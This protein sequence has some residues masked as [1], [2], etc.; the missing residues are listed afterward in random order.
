[1]KTLLPGRH[2]VVGGTE[3]VRENTG[4]EDFVFDLCAPHAQRTAEAPRRGRTR[5]QL[6]DWK[7]T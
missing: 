1:M 7:P 6:E 3:G 5:A 4:L 2:T